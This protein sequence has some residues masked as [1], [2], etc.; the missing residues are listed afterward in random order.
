VSTAGLLMTAAA[1]GG[2]LLLAIAGLQKLRGREPLSAVVRAHDVLPAPVARVVVPLVPFGELAVALAFVL[3]QVLSG[4]LRVVLLALFSA[5]TSAYTAYLL[6]VLRRGSGASCGCLGSREPVNPLHVV[7][8]GLIA[9]SGA[10][11]AFSSGSPAAAEPFQVLAAALLSGFCAL[12]YWV[13]PLTA[14]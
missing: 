6:L 2:A 3:A 4:T 5:W 14:A 12:L 7:R 13:A 9:L 1:G 8:V 10:L 11:L